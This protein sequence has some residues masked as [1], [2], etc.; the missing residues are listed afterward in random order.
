MRRVGEPMSSYEERVHNREALLSGNVP[1]RVPVHL[2]ITM[3]AAC[4]FA[5]VDLLK[6]HYDLEL[7]EKAYKAICENFYTDTFPVRNSRF[8]AIYQLLGAKNWVLSST[9][10]M[11]HPEIEVMTAEDY[12][13]FIE[14]PFGCIMG[15]FLPRVYKSLDT[16]DINR[17]LIFAKSYRMFVKRKEAETAIAGALSEKYGY[18]PGTIFGGELI[19]APFDFLADLLRGFKQATMDLRRRPDKVKAACEAILPLML[20]LATPPVIRPGI[21]HFVPLHLAPYINMTQFE[22]YYWPTF[23]EMVVELDRRGMG[24]HLFVE[25]D[26]T[27]F[28]QHLARLPESSRMHFEYGDPALIKQTAGQNHVIG[29]F[30]DPTI[31]LTR[32]TQECID[33]AKRLIDICAPGGRYYF[34]FDKGIMDMKSVDPKKVQAV[35]EWVHVNTDY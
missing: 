30:Y 8:P 34:C 29:G 14:N 18:V 5:G 2:N 9:G 12:D 3:E 32:S 15:T 25:S 6:A 19:E 17:N 7:L 27:R 24:C 26:W 33:E 1:K 22:A 20:K 4:G 21:S 35:L 13:E 10:V 23:E 11:Q 28:A 31:T 16:D